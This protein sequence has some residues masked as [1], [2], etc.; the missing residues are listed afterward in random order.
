MNKGLKL[1]EEALSVIPGG[2]GL[3]SKR[4]S[5]YLPDMWP[6]YFDSAKGVEITDLEGN[7]YIDM[8]QMG[9]GTAILGYCDDDVDAAV[10]KAVGKCVNATLNVPEEVELAKVLLSLN[11]FAG[12][13]KFARSGG[14][15]MAVAV[16][17]AR[18]FS[19]RDKVAFSGY[20]GW[21]DWYIAANL[22]G[23]DSLKGHLLP[24]LE[25][26]GVP[27]GLK[28]SAVGF[29]YNDA[30]EFR[31]VL[32]DNPDIGVVVIEG[33]RYEMPSKRFFDVIFS[34]C[35]KRGIVVIL[36][37]ITSGWRLTDGGVYK[38]LNAEP[39]IVVYGKAMGNG[40]AISAVVGKK[41]VM[42]AANDTFISS[43]FWTERIGFAAAIATIN[44][45]CENKVWEHLCRTGSR[46][47][48]IW[49]EA[50][51]KYGL[52]I[53]VTEFKPL[54]TFKFNYGSDNNALSTLF[55]QL[56][57]ERGYLAANSVY[58][59]C[60]HTDGII[61]RYAEAVDEVFALISGGIKKGNLREL[62]KSNVKEDG[63]KR[64]T[65]VK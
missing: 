62:L 34:E 26:K 48:A 44:K 46:I 41:D 57:L 23:S 11:P 19:G 47:G 58:V 64:L 21:C 50:A 39:D 37:E 7:N 36:D 22:G 43:T 53:T 10:T 45:L 25:P 35:D 3:L 16:R 60:A 5:R 63:F 12:G 17:I 38:V 6:T 4:P 14:E 9:I 40:Y 13:V 55:T 59:S 49:S 31:A 30:E 52:D 56:M 32:K 2:N 20:H 24:G 8:A 51:G 54:I 27:S 18:A 42:S 65:E 28:G 33:A 15:A 29:K 61:D 1:W